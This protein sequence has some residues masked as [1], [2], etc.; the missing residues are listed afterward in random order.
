MTMTPEEIAQ[1]LD[2][3]HKLD[4]AVVEVTVGD[5]R[6]AV[7]RDS[8]GEAMQSSPV[9]A[10]GAVQPASGPPPPEASAGPVPVQADEATSAWLEREAQGSAIIVRAP[11][12]GTFYRAKAPGEPPFVEVGSAVAPGDTVGLVE[13]M[14]LFNSITVD[15]QGQVAAIFA[16]NGEMVEYGAPV[17]ALVGR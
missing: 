10:T 3:I 11:M 6:I 17:L 13:A 2:A 14:K 5:V 7:R 4:C 1:I 9:K 12:I 15:Q 8:A 16:D